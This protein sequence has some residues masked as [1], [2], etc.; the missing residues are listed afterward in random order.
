[1]INEGSQEEEEE[2]VEQKKRKLLVL[3]STKDNFYS[4]INCFIN[5]LVYKNVCVL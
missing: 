2:K 4:C 1:M 5:I 3:M